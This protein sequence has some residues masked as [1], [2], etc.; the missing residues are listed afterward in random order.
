MK[1]RRQVLLGIAALAAAG[2]GAFADSVAPGAGD[3]LVPRD[4]I[5]LATN[6]LLRSDSSRI[7][8]LEEKGSRAATPAPPAGTVVMSPYVLREPNDRDVA[9]PRYETP[10]MRFLRDGTLYSHVGQKFSSRL[11]LQLAQAEQHI[12]GNVP[13]SN[14][15]RLA[16]VLAW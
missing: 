15:I 4:D 10:T 14:A 2:C 13:P 5:R 9:M 8:A 12:G 1:P 3:S 11:F 7:A 16:F 6:I